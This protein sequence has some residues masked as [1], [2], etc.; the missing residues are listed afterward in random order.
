MKTERIKE[1]WKPV[2]ISNFE[3]YFEVSDKGNVRSISRT[4]KKVNKSGKTYDFPLTGR[5]RKQ[6]ISWGYYQVQLFANKKYSGQLVHRLVALAFIP[7]PEN[8]KEVNHKDGNKFNNAK[9]NLEWATTGE[10]QLHSYRVLNRK[11]AVVKGKN[12][13]CNKKIK[14]MKNG[15][16]IKKYHSASI[17]HRKTG[18]NLGDLCGA[19]NGRLKTAGGFTWE[20]L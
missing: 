10:N 16:M 20:Y 2:T 15:V 18:I 12:N 1:K 17:A 7:N 9:P 19:A 5:I 11:A 13:L 14:Q 6:S 8:K 4:I 3:R